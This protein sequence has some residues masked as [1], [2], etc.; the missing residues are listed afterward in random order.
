MEAGYETE[1]SVHETVITI[2]T[3]I[4]IEIDETMTMPVSAEGRIHR[5][6]LY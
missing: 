3:A 4:S 5:V 2:G 1:T 6:L